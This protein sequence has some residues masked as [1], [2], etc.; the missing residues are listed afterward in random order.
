MIGLTNSDKELLWIFGK[1]K[2]NFSGGVLLN[3]ITLRV[4]K[5]IKLSSKSCKKNGKEYGIIFNEWLTIFCTLGNRALTL[6]DVVTQFEPF[7][8][9]VS[10]YIYPLKISENLWF[11]NVFRDYKKRPVASTNYMF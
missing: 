9:P 5:M 6:E 7:H 3:P 1:G 10:F 4:D 8:A 11:C 2:E